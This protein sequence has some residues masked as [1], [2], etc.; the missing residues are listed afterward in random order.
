MVGWLQDL[1]LYHNLLKVYA[2]ILLQV[3]FLFIQTTTFIITEYNSKESTSINVIGINWEALAYDYLYFS[4]ATYS[5]AV[6]KYSGE[7]IA[8]DI[9][10]NQLGQMPSQIEA[11][12]H[13]LGAHLVGHLGRT[14]FDKSG[15][16][17]SRVTGK[18]YK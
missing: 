9:L 8:F 5:V 6:G 11:V 17:I 16:K 10:I 13:S 2:E 14:I 15:E 12:G 3:S 7:K 18:N 4:S 1:N